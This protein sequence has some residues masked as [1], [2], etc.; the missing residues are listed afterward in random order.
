MR[1][2][3]GKHTAKILASQSTVGLDLNTAKLVVGRIDRY[4]KDVA[5]ELLH[6]RNPLE[7]TY[8]Q[9]ESCSGGIMVAITKGYGKDQIKTAII[10]T[11]LKR[12]DESEV[13]AK[14]LNRI[15]ALMGLMEGRDINGEVLNIPQLEGIDLKDLKHISATL[16]S[17]AIR[18][19]TKTFAEEVRR[20]GAE[21]I[22]ILHP[23]YRLPESTP[24]KLSSQ[25][26][27][28]FEGEEKDPN[29][30]LQLTETSRLVSLNKDIDIGTTSAK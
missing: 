5:E 6:C 16:T 4:C 23:D 10:S 9:V 1:S 26:K 7:T 18:R 11:I 3:I 28:R 12:S 21:K 19:N 8:E 14:L 15:D 27:V 30:S 20:Y 17:E 13:S 22:D 24:K 29:S 25:K 2:V